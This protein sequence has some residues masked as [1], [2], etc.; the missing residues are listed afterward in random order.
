MSSDERRGRQ[1]FG[2]ARPV[3]QWQQTPGAPAAA[4]AA[5][6]T[7]ARARRK[8]DVGQERQ[9]ERAGRVC[10]APVGQRLNNRRP[11]WRP[12]ARP[13]A[14]KFVIRLLA[15]RARPEWAKIEIN[16]PAGQFK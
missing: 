6:W 7:G 8:L 15:E 16:R 4:R 2:R 9:R 10:R 1:M 12:A 13:A 5:I 11:D 3:E 14:A